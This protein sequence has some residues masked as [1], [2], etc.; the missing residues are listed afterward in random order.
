MNKR[1]LLALAAIPVLALACVSASAQSANGAGTPAAPAYGRGYGMGSGMMGGYGPGA[2]QRGAD[3][4][5]GYGSGGWGMG[6]GMMGGWSG[7][8]G[9][10]PWMMGGG[11]GAYGGWGMGPW[12]MGGG[13]GMASLMMG[14]YFGPGAWAL[15]SLD[16]SDAQVQKIEA[17]QDAQE[18][19]QW[20]LM[21]AMHDAMLSGRRGFDQQS[22]DVDAVMKTAKAISDV[23]LQMMRNRLEAQKQILGVLTAQQQ[24]ALR[25]QYGRRGW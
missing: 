8:Y 3:D 1:N 14:G 6:P 12:M 20:A 19:K 24:E 13:Y 4:G 10:G 25:Q 2:M 21:T 9:M 22:L 16:L 11:Y 5:R 17:I 23:R 15:A 18:K 7:G